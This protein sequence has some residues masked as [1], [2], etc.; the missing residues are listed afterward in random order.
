L[1]NQQSGSI[2]EGWAYVLPTEAQWE[3]ACRAGTTTAFSWGNTINGE[4]AN[5][6][7]SGYAQTRN[8]G[9][10]PANL[11]GFFDMHGNVW[12]WTADASSPYTAS[13]QVDPYNQGGTDS[14][15]VSRGGSWGYS[16]E[17]LQSA[18]RAFNLSTHR[19]SGFGFRVGFQIQ[20]DEASPELELFGGA[21]IPHKRDEPWA[22][23][24]YGATDV[25][26]GN[27]TSSV[28]ISGTVDVNTTGTYTLVYSVSNTAGN[29]A[30]ATRTVRVINYITYDA[31]SLDGALSTIS[32][33][34]A[35]HVG[36]E[37]PE[38]QDFLLNHSPTIPSGLNV[39]FHSD[40]DLYILKP[41]SYSGE[42]TITL[43]AGGSIFV[44]ASI[45][46]SHTNGKLAAHYGLSEPSVDNPHF[47]IVA[48]PINLELGENFFSQHGIGGEYKSYQIIHELGE[49]NSTTGTDLQGMQAQPDQNYALGRDIN[50][51]ATQEW[52]LYN[53]F[54]SF[55]KANDLEGLG[56]K[57]LGPF[58]GNLFSNY[59]NG[60]LSNFYFETFWQENEASEAK[61]MIAA[62]MIDAKI[63]NIETHSK[64]NS[65]IL[66]DNEK[67]TYL[68]GIGSIARSAE[69]TKVYFSKAKVEIYGNSNLGGFF[70]TANSCLISNS[71]TIG[72][73]DGVNTDSYL[74]NWRAQNVGGF[75]GIASSTQIKNS[76][77]LISP[78]GWKEFNGNSQSIEAYFDAAGAEDSTF[79]NFGHIFGYADSS[80]SSASSFS[81]VLRYFKLWPYDESPWITHLDSFGAENGQEITDTSV[82]QTAGW[83]TD[84]IWQM[85]DGEYPIFKWN[86]PLDEPLGDLNSTNY[87]TIVENQPIG[88]IMGEFNTTDANEGTITYHFVNGENNNSLFTLDT[89]GTLKTATTFD[90]E[91]NASTY[92]ITVQAKDELNATTEGNFIVSLLDQDEGEAPTL[93]D[94]TTENPYQVTT[95]ANLKWLS[96]TPS[97][98]NAK[99]IQT[100][101]INASDTRNWDD[102]KGFKPIGFDYDN[103]FSGGYDGSNHLITDLFINRPDQNVGLFGYIQG[104]QGQVVS[105]VNLL[106]IHLIGSATGSI[107]GEAFGGLVVEYCSSV[108]ANLT[109]TNVG[110]LVGY[111]IMGGGSIKFSSF[112]G[113]IDGEEKVGGIVGE[114]GDTAIDSC[115]AISQFSDG[116]TIKGGIA[117]SIWYG[118]RFNGVS[119]NFSVS[120]LPLYGSYSFDDYFE[121]PLN[122]TSF[123]DS[124]ISSTNPV[125]ESWA[126]GKTT[127]EMK[128]K[129]TFVDAGWDF[130]D[131]WFMPENG[132]PILRWQVT[133]FPPK[134]LNFTAVLMITEN[135]PVGAVVGELNATDPE[136]GSITYQ[137]VGGEGDTHNSLFNLEANGT[138]RT[139][140]L[141]DYESNASVYSIRVQAM[142][143]HYASVEASFTINL[144]DDVDEDTDGD[145]FKDKFE[146]EY[147]T[148]IRSA[149]SKPG[150]KL[151][152]AVMAVGT[153]EPL[154][155]TPTFSGHPLFGGVKYLLPRVESVGKGYTIVDTP[156]VFIYRGDQIVTG[157]TGVATRNSDGTLSLSFEG[158]A[159]SEEPVTVTVAHGVPWPSKIGVFRHEHPPLELIPEFTGHYLFGGVRYVLGDVS[160][161]GS[162]FTS[163]ISPEIILRRGQQD[164]AGVSIL[165]TT[166]EDGSLDISFEGSAGSTDPVS[167]ILP[168]T[169]SL[170]DKNKVVTMPFSITDQNFQDEVLL[171][172]S[173]V[174]TLVANYTLSGNQDLTEEQEGDSRFIHFNFSGQP[175]SLDT[176]EAVLFY[177]D[178]PNAE[179]VDLN[180]TTVLSIAENQ[181]V[182][183]YI[184][185]FLA[186]HSDG[187]E[188][189]Y[190]LVNGVGDS[191]N[192]LFHLETNGTLRSEAIFDYETNASSYLIRV[193][194]ESEDG[195][196]LEASFMISL[197]DAD[198]EPPVIS[199]FGDVNITHEAGTLFHDPGASWADN[200]DG[201][202]EIFGLGEVNASKPG[203]YFLIYDHVD[204]TGNEAESITRTVTVV[205]TTAPV[206]TLTG[207]PEIILEAGS[208]YIDLGASWTDMVDGNGTFLGQGEVD[209]LVPGVY[210]LTY[211]KTDQAGNEAITLMRTVAVVDTTAP[212][213][214]LTGEPEIIL[215]AG[216]TYIDPGASWTDIVDGNGTL[217]GQGEINS[218]VPGVYE[219]TYSKTDQ[220]G[221]AAITVMRTVAVV[222]T[223]SP[224]ITLIGEPEIILEAGIAYIDPRASWTDIVDGNG[225]LSGQGEINSFVPGFYQLTYSKTDEAG[226]AA[227][228]VTRTVTVVNDAPNNLVLSGNEVEENLPANTLVGQFSWSDPNDP[229]GTGNYQLELVNEEGKANFLLDEN[230][231]LLT[232]TSL[233]FETAPS[234][235]LVVLLSDAY[236]GSMEESFTIE[237]IDAFLPIVYT[238]D[239]IEVG[240]R[241]VVASGEVMDEG[242]SLGVNARGFLVSS[243]AEARVED[244]E[245]IHVL[246]GEGAGSYTHRVNGL[247]PDQKYYVRAYATNAEGTA[248][249]AS[250]RLYSQAYDV[251]PDWSNATPSAYVEG[252]WSSPWFGTFYTQ[253]DSGW[254]H[255]AAL[256]WA[257][258]MPVKDGGVWLWTEATGWA[259]TEQGTYPFLYANDWQ[260]W[261]YFYGQSKGQIIF[262]RYSDHEWVIKVK[263]EIK[264]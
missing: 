33:S 37:G 147:G 62:T 239:P 86:V 69:S 135:Q 11:W 158:S 199:L 144:V 225:T 208:K 64:I 149:E 40:Q 76:Y 215:E 6:P 256:G 230:G 211:S 114:L 28:S 79:T 223:T 8:V 100:A 128:T 261:L 190:L 13:S 203:M 24:G 222:D 176:V 44:Q 132:Y 72:S 169:Y 42:Q 121:E 224:V 32:N 183:T 188:L 7:S 120:N 210:Q 25:H 198:D 12:E 61:G 2:P 98:W 159:G 4:H 111:V 59:S 94:G 157:V 43:S 21:D 34:G 84:K 229:G 174:G 92:T 204:Q 241:H 117:G 20:P 142:D 163:G 232:R 27:L 171:L 240:A 105:K 115:Y 185:E 78:W 39:I 55:N 65:G 196:F 14:Y 162:H 102:G 166:N 234:H 57:I 243:F 45:T 133:N 251:A 231:T 23:P 101:D 41:F 95:L 214:T 129:S 104:G 122:L 136:S 119:Q 207:E 17:T 46:A 195:L 156:E 137:L 155:L 131:T 260:S 87:L 118:A 106:N 10:Y 138:L 22:E 217:L 245:V 56:H 218:L 130:N 244:A 116:G 75:A 250:L 191:D 67:V 29:E 205:D 107:V 47:F 248:Y 193:R 254:V 60:M 238:E 127:Q 110:G 74:S 220:G 83:D 257:Y 181:P 26:D 194:A 253:D 173:G 189:T 141:F 209:S 36:I 258:A 9:F 206:I 82:F 145:G 31:S 77:T 227:I 180:S 1:N 93:G 151:Q 213:I 66:D 80:S 242:H 112:E 54:R 187:V 35:T 68:A 247:Q 201:F 48:Q 3:Y 246:A 233:D 259:W 152:I 124:N 70:G 197:S 30:N 53:G 192:H 216:S 178:G 140:T 146:R 139:A 18:R 164:V 167:L 148:D 123:W 168:D 154:V 237:V 255:H 113:S 153:M 134:D 212:V 63:L 221:N 235:E 226:N 177:D 249:G 170:V 186:T 165:S 236:G 172:G 182:G 88:T 184:G 97:V 16:S 219:L 71:V 38:G 161:I 263:N 228:T 15:R 252:W 49:E 126:V 179:L 200:T 51:S 143:E 108:D 91:S 73:I 103:S 58:Q 202:G 109:G 85:A 52:N 264:Q 19:N 125:L 81:P 99:F 50:A 96:M 160:A 89:N 5:G 150:V 175:S 262:F 90:Y